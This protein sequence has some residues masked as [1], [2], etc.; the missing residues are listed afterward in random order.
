MGY[1][2]KESADRA[3]TVADR[4]T[5][6]EATITVSGAEYNVPVLSSSHRRRQQRNIRIA[7]RNRVEAEREKRFQSHEQHRREVIVLR[8]LETIRTRYN[9]NL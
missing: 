9:Q 4:D 5:D 3:F 8:M 7:Y 1:T 2:R 6:S